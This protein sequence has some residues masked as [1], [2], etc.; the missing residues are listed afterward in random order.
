MT[1][2]RYYFSRIA[3]AFGIHRRNQRM[4]DAASETHLLREAEAYLGALVWEKTEHIEPLATSYWNLRK[5]SHERDAVSTKLASCQERLNKAHEERAGLLNT[6][7]EPE[8]K[9]NSEK[10]E[11]VT[12]LNSLAARR[13]EVVAAAK[14]IRRSYEGLKVKSEVLANETGKAKPGDQD[15]DKIN[16]S[17]NQL[18]VRFTALKTERTEISAEIEKGDAR[19]NDLAEQIRE[20]KKTQH[21]FASKAFQVIGDANKDISALRA[22]Y[23]ILDTRM[24]QLHAEIGRHISRNA[25]DDPACAE[26]AK[27]HMGLV[28]VMRALRKSITLNYKLAEM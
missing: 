11:I 27:G 13:D 26:A 15:I 12:R 18:K 19:I 4:G 22:E 2:T 16:A 7:S 6:V 20:L 1:P 3:R 25:S 10:A 23:G 14:E 9:L 24:T 17:L 8:Q 5:L 21:E 28:E